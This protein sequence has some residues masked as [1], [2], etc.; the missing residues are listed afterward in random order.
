MLR[1]ALTRASK[2]VIEKIA[3]EIVPQ[4]AETIIR[5]HLDQLI[6]DRNGRS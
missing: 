4:L 2:D 3:W 5:E 6:K 1:E